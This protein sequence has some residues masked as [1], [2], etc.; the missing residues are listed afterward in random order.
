M[1]K[2]T[3]LIVDDEPYILEELVETLEFEGYQCLA[4]ERVDTA[5]ELL[6][7]GAKTDVLLTDIKMPGRSGLELIAYAEGSQSFDGCV[8]IMSG[9][10]TSDGEISRPM[11][12]EYS[13]LKKPIHVDELLQMINALL[14]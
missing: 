2:A 3:I 8:I 13:F 1:T 9:H 5:I 6:A 12:G 10:G 4:A 14:A 7:S 11:N